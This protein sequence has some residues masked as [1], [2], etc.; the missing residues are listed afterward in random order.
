M[1]GSRD[2]AARCEL[3]LGEAGY[4]ARVA[5]LAAPPERLYV[6]GNADALG[7]TS[8]SVIGAR[9]ATPYGLACAEMAAQVAAESGVTVV[10]GGARGCDQAAGFAALDAGGVHVVVLG[11]GADVVYPAS[12]RRLIER[13]LD[14]GGAVVSL[15]SWGAPPQRWAFPK[16][17]RVIAALSAALFVTEAGMPSGTFGTA[18][19]SVELG[20]EV[21][22]TPGSILS[23]QS[24]GANYLISQGACCIPDVEAL[25]V[26][27]SRIYGTLRYD[28]RRRAEPAL[29]AREQRVLD[30]LVADPMRPDALAAAL[31][32][33]ELSCMRLLGSCAAR[34]LVEQLLDGRFSL[35]RAALHA[36]GGLGQNRAT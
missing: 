27:I 18:E 11:C 3:R 26:A 8:L 20:R 19:T 4:P 22:V 2:T 10:S 24:R 32:M 23:A 34:G 17:N 35:T 36:R 1:G 25:E 12:S 16:R 5:E 9:R 29:D 28:R 7:C 13:A 30:C 21:L 6:R 15:E 14:A 33:D 31:R